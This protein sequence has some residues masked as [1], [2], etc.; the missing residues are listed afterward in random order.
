MTGTHKPLRGFAALPPE[1]RKEIAARGGANV[2]A[3]KRAYATNRALASAAG[4]AGG[5]NVPPGARSFSLDRQLAAEAGRKGGKRSRKRPK[6]SAGPEAGA[7]PEAQPE[8][9][10]P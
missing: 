6:E 9:R 8:A 4:R 10:R 3:A 2:P 1:R 7:G 5:H